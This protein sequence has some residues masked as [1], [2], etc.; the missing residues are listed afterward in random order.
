MI[1]HSGLHLRLVMNHHGV[2]RTVLIL[3]LKVPCSRRP[4]HSRPNGMV[5]HTTVTSLPGCHSYHKLSSL[6]KYKPVVYALSAMLSSSV[7]TISSSNSGEE[8]KNWDF[9][10]IFSP[11]IL[12]HHKK[13]CT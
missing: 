9:S 2:L 5:G 1:S 13:T 3:A 12:C 6:F 8:L 4:L 10:H 11:V 7:L